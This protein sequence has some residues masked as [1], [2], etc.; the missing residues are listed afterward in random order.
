MAKEAKECGIMTALELV[1]LGR[2]AYYDR[3]SVG[4]GEGERRRRLFKRG[5]FTYS[6]V[7]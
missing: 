1:E 3:M 5:S 7:A 4:C 2:P 6:A